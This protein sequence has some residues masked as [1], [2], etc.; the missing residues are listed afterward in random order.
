MNA[1][2]IGDPDKNDMYLFSFKILRKM[3]WVKYVKLNADNQLSL[4]Y[5]E[6]VILLQHVNFFNRNSQVS[7]VTLFK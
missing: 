4:Q 5:L 6:G 2:G 3:S 1:T 7:T